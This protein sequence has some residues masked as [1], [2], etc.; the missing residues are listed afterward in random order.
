MKETGRKKLD[1]FED[2]QGG[3]WG[4]SGVSGEVGEAGKGQTL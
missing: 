4:R 3:W 1:K 2:Q